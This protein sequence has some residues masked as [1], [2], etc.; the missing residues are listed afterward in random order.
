MKDTMPQWSTRRAILHHG[1]VLAALALASRAARGQ[2]QPIERRT[3]FDDLYT[4]Q[5]DRAI[6][7]GLRFLLGRERDGQFPTARWGQNIGICSLAGLAFLSRGSRIDDRA[8]GEMVGR[9]ARRIQSL[10]QPNGFIFD[11][12]SRSHG[13]MYEHGFATLFLSEVQGTG[14][15]AD[16]QTTIKSA[17]E[18]IVLSQNE[19]GGW[20]YDPRPTEADV[21]VTVSQV[22]ALRA[23]K[24]GGF[25]VPEETI[26]RAID[27]LRR[28]Q[29]PDGGFTY[30]LDGGASRYALT[31]GALVAMYNS[32]IN[33]G[34]ELDRA[35]Q[36]LIA[37]RD[38]DRYL[39]TNYYFYAH[40][41]S[42]QAF[43]HRGGPTWNSWYRK[44]VDGI[45]PLQDPNG[46]WTD[47]SHGSEYA[48]AMA[49]L[50]LNTPRSLLPIY[51]R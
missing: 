25:F 15:K 21:S 22:M 32:G 23:A 26:T 8:D 16:F 1:T 9:L 30:Q 29:N 46:A 28:A 4:E 2:E 38:T 17:V 51:Q 39:Q 20:R 13:P 24:N 42:A 44:L 35:F 33:E 43:W 27:Y 48:T 40:Y 47:Q 3:D 37:D 41:Y 10:G 12:M 5:V 36:Y 34:K 18:L 50:I 14:V 19:Q 45:L 49:C 31:A 7:A 11:D 6:E